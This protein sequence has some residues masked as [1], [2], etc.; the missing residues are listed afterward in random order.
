MQMS[1][2]SGY[3]PDVVI[4]YTTHMHP[5]PLPSSSPSLP[6]GNTNNIYID[7]ED[8]TSAAERFAPLGIMGL[9]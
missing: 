5:L 8:F 3:S 1:F 6:P 4:R 2:F 7:M 9:N